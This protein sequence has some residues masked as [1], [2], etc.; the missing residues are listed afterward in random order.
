MRIKHHFSW[1]KNNSRNA[2]FTDLTSAMLYLQEI[3]SK[4]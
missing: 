3:T 4:Q 2:L 1:G